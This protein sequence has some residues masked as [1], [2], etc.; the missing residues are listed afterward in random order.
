MPF[1]EID[2]FDHGD[3][4]LS[5]ELN[6]LSDNDNYFNTVINPNIYGAK[7]GSRIAYFHTYRF[8]F[9]SGSGDIVDISD[10]LNTVSVSSFPYDLDSISWMAYGKEYLAVNFDWTFERNSP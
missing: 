7:D 10:P 3:Y 2:R 8:L 9:G 4:P 6:K 1:T 5:S